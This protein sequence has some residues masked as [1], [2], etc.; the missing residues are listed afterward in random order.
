MSNPNSML[1]LIRRCIVKLVEVRPDPGEGWCID[2][3]LNDDRTLII[4]ADGLQEHVLLH[5]PGDYVY[6][7]TTRKNLPKE[8]PR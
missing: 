7:E 1:T 4:S 5:A 2:C 6:I 8:M 3:C